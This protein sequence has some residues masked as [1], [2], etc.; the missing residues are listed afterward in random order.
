MNP[1]DKSSNKKKLPIWKKALIHSTICFVMGF[2]T[3]FAPTTITS[4][5]NRTH[6]P[7]SKLSVLPESINSLHK[8][9]SQHVLNQSLIAQLPMRSNPDPLPDKPLESDPKGLLIIITTTQ[10]GDPTQAASLTR[11]AHTLKLVHPPLLWVVV[12]SRVNA[13][14]T[15][16]LLRDT[17]VMYRHITYKENFTDFEEEVHHQRNAALSHLEHHRITGLVH[18]ADRLNFYDPRFFEEIRQI[19]VFG[20]WPVATMGRNMK[21]VEVE[22][23]ICKSSKVVGWY[24]KDSSN[25]PTAAASLVPEGE[26]NKRQAGLKPDRINISGFGFNSSILWDPE[27]WGR[28]TSQPDTSQDSMRFVQELVLQDEAKLKGIPPDCSQVMV[29]HLHTSSSANKKNRR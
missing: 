21:K 2:F 26:E 24:K 7:I 12:E 14:E 18:F 5:P 23:P 15:A 29:W 9:S 4:E 20:T 17:G 22:G 25:A 27:R 13:P 28:P 8:S 19:E 10:Y 6:Q 16:R 11:M 3:G 1:L